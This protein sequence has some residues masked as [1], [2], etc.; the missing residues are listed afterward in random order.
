MLIKGLLLTLYILRCNLE[1][2]LID[3]EAQQVPV[4][5]HQNTSS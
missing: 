5:S 1:L 2:L 4:P 3:I